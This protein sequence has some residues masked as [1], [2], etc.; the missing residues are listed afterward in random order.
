MVLDIVLFGAEITVVGESDSELSTKI[1]KR[2]FI[3]VFDTC[4]QV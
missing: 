2:G 4:E 1:L 3:Q